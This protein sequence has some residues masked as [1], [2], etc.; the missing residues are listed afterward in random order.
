MMQARRTRQAPAPF[1][2]ALALG[3]PA[4]VHA[5]FDANGDL[6][7]GSIAFGKGVS[8]RAAQGSMRLVVPPLPD[9]I[10]SA[11]TGRHVSSVVDHPWLGDP[12]LVIERVD[13]EDG[14]M[15]LAIASAPTTISA[16]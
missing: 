2:A 10:A 15:T 16:E 4:G 1:A 12:R 13:H 6:D 11:L 9:T 3:S 14:R 8:L 7:T 5:E